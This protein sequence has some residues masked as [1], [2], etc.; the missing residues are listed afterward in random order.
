M[1]TTVKPPTWFWVV[2]IIALLWNLMG[3]FNY[4]NQ[5][6]NQQAILETLDQAQ[7][8]AFEGIPAWATAAFA[9][10]VF[11]GTLACI[12]L[13]LRKKWA[14]PLFILSLLAAVV[15]FIHWLFISNA[16]EAFGPST[17]AMPVIVIIIGIYLILFS[18][19]GIE[20]GWL[21]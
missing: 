12:G 9:L 7:R 3:V 2:S 16:V 8:E 6:F 5:A 15:Q 13:L 1:T 21:T 14:R 20:K 4:L 18:K 19:K 10:A 11:S 17:Y